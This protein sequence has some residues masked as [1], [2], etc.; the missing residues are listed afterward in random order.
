MEIIQAH[1]DDESQSVDF[2]KI[3]IDYSHFV[4]KKI[5]DSNTSLIELNDSI[6]ILERLLKK[7]K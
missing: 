1:K 6:R 4:E 5:Q 2:Q 7:F 3:V